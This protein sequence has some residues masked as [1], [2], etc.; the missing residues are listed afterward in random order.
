MNIPTLEEFAANVL[1]EL[2]QVSLDTPQK[3]ADAVAGFFT[4]RGTWIQER[5]SSSPCFLDKKKVTEEML[6]LGVATATV[7]MMSLGESL[8][9]SQHLEELAYIAS[10]RMAL[11]ALIVGM[12]HYAPADSIS[13]SVL[14]DLKEKLVVLD[15]AIV[16]RATEL[17]GDLEEAFR[18]VLKEEL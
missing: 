14:R 18:R 2:S 5:G 13:I 1:N 10:D 8:S 4:M 17:G 3:Y 16:Q 6:L 11:E 9:E 12:E 7:D 15:G